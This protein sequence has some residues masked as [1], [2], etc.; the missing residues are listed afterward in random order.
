MSNKREGIA[1]TT[2]FPLHSNKGE[3]LDRAF[4]SAGRELMTPYQVRDLVNTA[5]AAPTYGTETTLLA[6]V[7]DNFL[8]L[9]E[10]SFANASAQAFSVELRD[11]TGGGVVKNFSIPTRDTKIVQFPIPLPQNAR[12]DTWTVKITNPV[13][14]QPDPGVIV[15]ATFIRN[16]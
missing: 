2:N 11:A 8:D 4:D 6:G 16:I 12:S 7:A 15:S 1:R 14:D 3:V 9:M 13:S 10:I 5:Y